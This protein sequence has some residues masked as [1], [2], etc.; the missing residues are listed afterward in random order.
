MSESNPILPEPEAVV[1]ALLQR[2]NSRKASAMI[3]LYAPDVA[4]FAQDGPAITDRIEIA[5]QLEHEIELGL[6]SAAT[7]TW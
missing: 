6:A 4:F 5:G 7:V 3:S 1:A 2:F